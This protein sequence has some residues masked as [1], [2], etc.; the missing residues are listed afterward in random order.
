LIF[1]PRIGSARATLLGG[2][3]RLAIEN[4]GGRLGF[5]ARLPA[6]ALA[7]AVMDG[8]PG[9]ILLPETEVM[10]DNAVGR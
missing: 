1:F 8:F 9:T 4:D 3:D 10:K 5:L 2:L 6:D 7:E